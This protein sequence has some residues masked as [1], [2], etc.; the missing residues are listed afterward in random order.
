[1][2]QLKILV[3]DD[4]EAHRRRLCRIIR[5]VPRFTLIG[6]AQN[7]TE[8]VSYAKKKQPDIILMDIE[9]EDASAG[10]R[11]SAEINQIA[12][13][14]KIIILTIHIDN[15]SIFSAY[16][17][18]ISDYVVKSAAKE[19]VIEAIDQAA[20]NTSSIRPYIANKLKEEFARVKHFEENFTHIFNVIAT[21]TPS[22]IEILKSLCQG[23]NRKQI[24]AERSVEL[25]TIKKQIS[26]ILKKFHKRNTREVLQFID[27][28]DVMTMIAKI[29]YD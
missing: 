7:A 2:K 4:M 23:R 25:E 14:A 27:E 12:P 1:M 22:E 11:A 6:T 19:E 13:N 9:M 8:A 29:S 10:I 18:N 28:H 20:Q 5:D 17:T 3:V 15:Q 26:S 16:Q 21:L 24:A